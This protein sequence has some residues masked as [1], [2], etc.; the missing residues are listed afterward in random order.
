MVAL[1][2]GSEITFRVGMKAFSSQTTNATAFSNTKTDF[3][4]SITDP[5]VN[6]GSYLCLSAVAIILAAITF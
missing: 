4:F 3:T 5:A 1:K 6:S 2:L